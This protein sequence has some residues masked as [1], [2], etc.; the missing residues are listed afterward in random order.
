MLLDQQVPEWD[1]RRVERRIVHAPADVVLR[2]AMTVDFLDAVRRS[3]VVTFL[4][5]MRSTA[6]RL[7]AAVRRRPFAGPPTPTSL[8]LI[9]LPATG[10]WVRLGETPSEVTFGVVG[11]FWGGDTRWSTIDATDFAG[12]SQ[13]GFARIGCNIAVRKLDDERS[14]L[15]YEARTKATD[16]AS[17][18]AF[19]RYWRIVSPFV[20]VVMRSTLSVIA[21]RAARLAQNER[22]IAP[23]SLPSPRYSDNAHAT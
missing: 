1:A 10:E 16:D 18:R 11:R 22:E 19:L 20:G 17:R 3:A 4:F 23:A 15:T 7:V 12:F 21:Q 8:R 13:P 9:D 14:L 5:A 6:E 2:S